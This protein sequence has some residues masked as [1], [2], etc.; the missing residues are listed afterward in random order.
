MM[1]TNGIWMEMQMLDGHISVVCAVHVQGR[2]LISDGGVDEVVVWGD[3]ENEEQMMW[4]Q[5]ATARISDLLGRHD[6]TAD[7]LLRATAVGRGAKCLSC[8]KLKRR[9]AHVGQ[10][11]GYGVMEDA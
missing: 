4:R 2:L 3:P 5:L 9:G 1:P 10:R 8:W 7:P 11:R 6:M